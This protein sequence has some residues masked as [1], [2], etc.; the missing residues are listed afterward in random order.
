MI[1]IIVL[2]IPLCTELFF[3]RGTGKI[4]K[5]IYWFIV[6]QKKT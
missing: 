3:N 6:V 5:F 2:I 4:E 1:A